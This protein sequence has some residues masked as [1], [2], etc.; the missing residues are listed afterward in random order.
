M[1]KL[2]DS[3]CGQH[4]PQQITLTGLAAVLVSRLIFNL[5][6][7]N[8]GH[9]YICGHGHTHYVTLNPCEEKMTSS[10]PGHGYAGGTAP[11]H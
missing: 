11:V 2:T 1:L 8:D 7:Y 10:P 6:L 4:R 5:P 3:G 9:S